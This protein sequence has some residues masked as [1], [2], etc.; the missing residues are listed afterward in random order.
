MEQSS[1]TIMLCTDDICPSSVK[2]FWTYWDELKKSIPKLKLNCF[3]IPHHC[4]LESEHIGGWAKKRKAFKHWYSNNASWLSLHLHGYDHTY[5]P[6]NTR[7][8][9]LQEALIKTGKTLL[10]KLIERENFGY[11]APGYYLN[12][13]TRNILRK[14]KFLFICHQTAVE[15][16][17]EPNLFANFLLMQSHTNGKSADS[18]EK[19]YKK[20]LELEDCEFITFEELYEQPEKNPADS[21][22]L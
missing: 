12:N 5:P 4:R 6:E 8:A 14:E 9:I 20:L 7:N 22:V 11:K 21:A 13:D 18:I 15:W 2:K 10:S 16:I 17:Q 19:I 1:S 3:V